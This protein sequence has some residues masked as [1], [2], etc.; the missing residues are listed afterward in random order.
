MDY[1]IQLQSPEKQCCL[2]T[3][4]KSLLDELKKFNEEQKMSKECLEFQENILKDLNQ[5]SEELFG[6][7]VGF[8][9]KYSGTRVMWWIFL[10]W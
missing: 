10:A 8:V 2:E 5:R 7:W 1:P 3:R 6:K 4:P 9:L